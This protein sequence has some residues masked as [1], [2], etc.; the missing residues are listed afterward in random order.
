[1]SG[2]LLSCPSLIISNAAFWRHHMQSGHH[3]SSTEY[4]HPPALRATICY[5]ATIPCCTR[6]NISRQNTH[7]QQA[8]RVV[9]Y[10]TIT[11]C[12]VRTVLVKLRHT[13]VI[14]TPYFTVITVKY[15]TVY[16]TVV[17]LTGYGKKNAWRG[18]EHIFS[19]VLQKFQFFQSHLCG[20]CD[21]WKGAGSL[22]LKGGGPSSEGLGRLLE[23]GDCLL[24]FADII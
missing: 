10:G 4:V 17:R 15:G 24:L 7:H 6:L 12:T 19:Q 20:C 23:P 8:C 21:P 11:V 2:H 14:V 9:R 22:S 1:M 5:Q 16:G 13:T 18:S 3:D